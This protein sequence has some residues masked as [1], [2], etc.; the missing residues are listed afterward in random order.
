[1]KLPG[2]LLIC[3]VAGGCHSQSGDVCVSPRI[4]GQVLDAKT[5]EPLA[6]VTVRRGTSD[7]TASTAPKGGELMMRKPDVQ[8][9]PDGAF[10]LEREQVLTILPR[11]GWTSVRLSF[12]FPGYERFVTNIAIW[13]LPTNAP[14]T[15][16]NAGNIFLHHARQ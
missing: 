9:G 15:S 4:T 10:V 1:M 2:L 5:S 3:L 8:T 7:R 13:N 11:S 12:E 6:D 14:A 16:V